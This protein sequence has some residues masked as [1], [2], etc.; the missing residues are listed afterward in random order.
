MNGHQS[1][2]DD[3]HLR[4]GSMGDRTAATQTALL[5]AGELPCPVFHRGHQS[6]LL[7]E[8]SEAHAGVF[9]GV[10]DDLPYVWPSSDREADGP[11][12]IPPG[13]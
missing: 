12:G 1:R 7:R 13:A 5:R 8:D 6:A 11:T 10:P 4:P 3:R 9:P 2:P